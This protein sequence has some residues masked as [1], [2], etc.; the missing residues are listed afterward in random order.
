MNFNYRLIF[1]FAPHFHKI[2]EVFNKSGV[3][4]TY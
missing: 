3:T 2:N 1:K 4:F